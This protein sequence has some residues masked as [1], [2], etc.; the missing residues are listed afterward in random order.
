[1]MHE[2]CVLDQTF[3][4]SSRVKIRKSKEC[5]PAQGAGI[6][7]LQYPSSDASAMEK[8]PTAKLF[9]NIIIIHGD[10]IQANCTGFG[11]SNL[12]VD[13]H[14]LIVLATSIGGAP[15][16]ETEVDVELH[17]CPNSHC[18]PPRVFLHQCCH[19]HPPDDSHHKQP[20]LH[21]RLGLVYSSLHQFMK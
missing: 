3:V 20:L 2:P 16:L 8:M 21:R 19:E 5:S 14:V 10:I 7:H 4:I 18:P 6:F 1:M 13:H 11:L 9:Q 15:P 17:L 12:P